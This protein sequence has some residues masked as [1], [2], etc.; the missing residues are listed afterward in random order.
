MTKLSKFLSKVSGAHNNFLENYYDEW[1]LVY[2][3]PLVMCIIWLPRRV[4]HCGTYSIVGNSRA[5]EVIVFVVMFYSSRSNK[6]VERGL[7]ITQLLYDIIHDVFYL[8][9][10]HLYC[11]LILSELKSNYLLT[12]V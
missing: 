8:Q 10:S 5:L 9:Y 2:Y 3:Y 11:L 1:T 4:V 6:K 12:C 7:V